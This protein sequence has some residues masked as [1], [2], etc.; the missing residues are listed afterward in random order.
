MALNNY[1]TPW[2]PTYEATAALAWSTTGIGTL[3]AA[4]AAGLP[5]GTAS[6]YAALAL[7]FSG[8][9]LKQSWDSWEKKYT[10]Q[11][12]E[13][14]TV[15]SEQLQ[16][17]CLKVPDAIWLGYGFEWHTEHSQR[18]YDL[19]RSKPEHLEVPGWYKKLRKSNGIIDSNP[20]GA[21]WIHG[22]ETEEV[23][24]KFPII[25][26]AGHTLVIGTTGS[27]KTRL[28]ETVTTQAIHRDDVVICMDPKGDQDWAERLRKECLRKGKPFVYI[29]LAHPELSARM[30]PLKNWNSKSEIAS[31]LTSVIETIGSGS[32][33]STKYGWQ[34]MNDIVNG[35]LLLGERPTIKKIAKNALQ[36]PIELVARVLEK[37]LKEH[38]GISVF[39]QTLA[40]KKTKN[41]HRGEKLIELFSEHMSDYEDPDLES[42]IASAGHDQKHYSKIMIEVIPILKMLTS[43]EVG[44]LFSP[45]AAD[46][47]DTREIWDWNRIIK[48]KACVYVGLDML[49]NDVIGTVIGTSLIEDLKA[50]AGVRYNY[51]SDPIKISV[52]I[53]E[54]SETVNKGY[55][56]ILNKTRGAG[57]NN[58]FATQTVA[59]F[60]AKMGTQAEATQLLGNANNLI[61][62]RTVDTDTWDFVTRKFGICPIEI[63]NESQNVSTSSEKNLA[64]FGGGMSKSRG[65][66]DMDR[67]PS[68]CL[69]ALPNLQYFAVIAGGTIVK[70]R[71]PIITN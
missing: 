54:A 39:E 63:E 7:S 30:D 50:A 29:H 43:G 21:P 34:V 11:V 18:L 26:Q 46:I 5:L 68:E 62:L 47:H 33:F 22:V 41:I 8:L 53:D 3:I 36:P 65:F 23:S 31:R 64:H 38:L 4:N 14:P 42:L 55:V 51:D 17:W 70:G 28:Y 58:T 19:M 56:Q 13:L 37:L 67:I 61:V 45:D 52:F 40:G 2:R 35:L 6:I 10:L 69:G 20:I 71:L 49:S 57:F 59:D 27:G 66:Q 25:A 48:Q 24:V 16:D 15:K 32:S 12:K 44:D 9:R 1:E 60:T